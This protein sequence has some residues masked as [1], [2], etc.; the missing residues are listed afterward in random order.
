MRGRTA[1]YPSGAAR[2]TACFSGE[3]T[4]KVNEGAGEGGTFEL[5]RTSVLG[6]TFVSS[7]IEWRDTRAEYLRRW[8]VRV[9]G[10][11]SDAL[12]FHWT[13]EDDLNLPITS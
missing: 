6:K 2:L 11:K 3:N 1:E 12:Y 13:P 7:Y 10:V 8:P 9:G 4:L 5:P